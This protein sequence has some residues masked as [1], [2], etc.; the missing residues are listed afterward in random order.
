M[1]F[2][3]SVRK[4]EAFVFISLQGRSRFEPIP[5]TK[6]VLFFYFLLSTVFFYFICFTNALNI[7]KLL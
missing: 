6:N 1:V 2:L 4:V 5:I 3:L 7:R